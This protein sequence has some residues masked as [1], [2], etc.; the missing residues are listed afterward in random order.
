[1]LPVARLQP[2]T[3]RTG[4][5][6]GNCADVAGQSV[7]RKRHVAADEDGV[8]VTGDVDRHDV[9]KDVAHGSGQR[10]DEPVVGHRCGRR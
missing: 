9:G 8:V 10:V 5:V 2:A 1:M 3:S 7:G 4:D 6:A